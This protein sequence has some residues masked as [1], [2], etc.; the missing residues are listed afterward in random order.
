MTGTHG[1]FNQAAD[2]AYGTIFIL[3][4]LIG[5]IG[6]SISFTFFS[7][8]KRE[9]SS[10]I[11][12]LITATDILVS[13]VALP[14]GISFCSQRQPGFI[15][16]SDFGCESWVCLWY[17]SISISIFLVLCLS[18]SR[19]LS[20]I[21]PFQKRRVKHLS[22]T[23]LT[24]QLIQI[25]AFQTLKHSSNSV[26]YPE[27]GRC[28]ITFS[29]FS[30][31]SIHLQRAIRILTCVAPAF[32]VAISSFISA[33]SLTKQNTLQTQQGTLHRSRRRATW[34]ILLFASLYGVCNLPFVLDYI[35]KVYRHYVEERQWNENVAKFDR[36]GL[37]FHNSRTTL[38]WP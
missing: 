9:I 20:L 15:F 30:T 33:V 4:F 18:I 31:A 25:T 34:T 36:T 28:D 22:K 1:K 8:K 16:G 11:Y 6:N 2:I 38:R 29:P 23:S 27:F 5:T 3:C 26:Y 7:S 21:R 32:V 13:I 37:Y 19:T 35:I 24:I 14:V 17:G 10:V 12:I